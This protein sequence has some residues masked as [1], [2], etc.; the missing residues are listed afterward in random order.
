MVKDWGPSSE[1]FRV[2]VGGT[3]ALVGAAREAGVRRF[4][5]TSS[6]GVHRYRG[7]RDADETLPRDANINAYCRSKIAAE[8]VVRE[9]A[10]EME[11]TIVRPGTFPFGPRD[12]QT[13]Y[14][15]ARAIEHRSLGY[16]N[17][18]RSLIS[19]VFVE[20]LALGMRLALEHPAAAA[21]VFVIGDDWRG[22]WR[23]LLTRIA[24]ELGVPPPRL[25]L[26]LRPAY[27]LAWLWEGLYRLLGVRSA[28]LL[29]RYRVLVAGRDCH[30]VSDKAR[31]VIGYQPRVGMD[32]AIRRSVAWYRA[33]SGRG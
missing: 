33:E 30:F 24:E 5:L 21:S 3:R 7:L 8:D 26:P 10:G 20:N 25:S 15:M 27:A 32:E 29:T 2:N 19:T 12:R 22:T 6:V 18:G 31:R 17:G 16:I 11:W 14:S 23:D 28:P 4:V 1:F 13:F 9:Q